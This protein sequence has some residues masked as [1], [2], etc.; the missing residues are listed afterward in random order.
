MDEIYGIVDDYMSIVKEDFNVFGGF[1][2]SGWIFLIDKIGYIWFYV[3][4]ID[5]EKVD[6]LLI[7][8]EW[9]LVNE[10]IWAF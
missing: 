8:I 2:Y 5:F 9:L 6:C 10:Q 7:D 3:D 1:D 4:G